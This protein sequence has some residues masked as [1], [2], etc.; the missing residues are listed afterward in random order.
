M[1]KIPLK[2]IFCIVMLVLIPTLFFTTNDYKNNYNFDTFLAL[3]I[4]ILLLIEVIS[5]FQKKQN[6]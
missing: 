6:K 2:I 5:Y 3:V 1:N 4:Y